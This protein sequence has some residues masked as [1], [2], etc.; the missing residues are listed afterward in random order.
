VAVG[1]HV[2]ADV[3]ALFGEAPELLPGHRHRHR[4]VDEPLAEPGSAVGPLLGVVARLL[5]DGPKV[6]RQSGYFSSDLTR[7]YW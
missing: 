7:S 5:D 4:R 1:T 2:D 6:T 3:H